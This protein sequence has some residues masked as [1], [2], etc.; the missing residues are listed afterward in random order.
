MILQRAK[1]Y[2]S[3]IIAVESIFGTSYRCALTIH[4]I[5]GE[6]HLADIYHDDKQTLEQIVQVWQSTPRIMDV[7]EN[8]NLTF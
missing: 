2:A 8:Q 1:I 5:D 7:F 3:P 4:Q 6:H